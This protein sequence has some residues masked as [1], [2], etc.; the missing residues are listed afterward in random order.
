MSWEQDII[1]KTNERLLSIAFQVTNANEFEKGI[2]DDLSYSEDFRVE[3]TGKEV[4]DKLQLEMAA[5]ATEKVAFITKME[6]LVTAIDQLPN[7]KCDRWQIQGYEKHLGDVPRQYTYEQLYPGNNDKK[8][9]INYPMVET[10]AP[11]ITKNIT[12]KMREYNQLAS[13]YV[14]RCINAIILKTVID[15]L[16]DNKKIKL[17]PQLASQLGF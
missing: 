4:K 10:P 16:S 14:R 17:A 13:D 5:I 7:G 11:V 8:E 1:Q 2:V 6:V 12:D 15:N 3:K 9:D